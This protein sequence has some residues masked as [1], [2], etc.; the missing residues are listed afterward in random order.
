VQDELAALA[1][2]GKIHKVEHPIVWERGLGDPVEQSEPRY[3]L[4]T[5]T[6]HAALDDEAP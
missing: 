5:A 4:L 3:E 2:R 6:E 1:K